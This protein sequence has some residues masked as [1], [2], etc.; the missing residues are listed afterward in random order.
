MILGICQKE[1]KSV[2]KRDTCKPTFTTAVHVNQQV[3][4]EMVYIHE[5]VLFSHKEE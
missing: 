3:D 2:D 5:G 1:C 4:K